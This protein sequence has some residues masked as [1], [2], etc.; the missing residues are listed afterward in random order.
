M[1]L[2]A[3]IVKDKKRFLQRQTQKLLLNDGTNKETHI[4]F[5]VRQSLK[6]KQG[7]CDA[8]YAAAHVEQTVERGR[9]CLY[10]TYIC[11]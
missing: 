4:E 9:Q 1:Y 6:R 11:Y 5:T 2:I 7:M 3:L 8:G 10:G